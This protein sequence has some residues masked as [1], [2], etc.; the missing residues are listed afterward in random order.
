MFKWISKLFRSDKQLRQ[1]VEQ[2]NL[3]ESEMREFSNE[4]IL[5]DSVS[6]KRLVQDSKMT[7]D[8]AL[9]RA[10]ALARETAKRVLSQRHFDVQLMGGIVLHQ[11]KIV[12]MRTGEG[13]TLAATLPAYLNALTGRG[14]H[15]V[16]VNEY[17]A[18]RDAVWMGQIYHAL[19]LKVSCLIHEGALLYDTNY[20][21][22]AGQSQ[23]LDKERDTTGS[24]WFKKNICVTS[25]AKRPIKPTLLTA[26]ITNLVLIIC[27]IIWSI[28][29]KIKSKGNAI[30]RLL[31]KWTVF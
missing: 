10:Y 22:E 28:N 9:P 4:R 2:I 15:V 17:L 16:T 23:L 21:R 7:L 19:G 20:K 12:E 27:G 5:E 13:K 25:A 26:P 1:V 3:L 11:G 18:K 29:W 8:E 6:L 31:T 14:V 24:F 30:M